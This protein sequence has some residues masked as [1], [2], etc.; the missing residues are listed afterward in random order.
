MQEQTP[1]EYLQDCVKIEPLC[2]EEEYIRLP[3]DMAYWNSRY[4]DVYRHWLEMKVAR[5]LAHN[6]LLME[7]REL[8][9][10]KSTSGRVTA[11]EV[12]SHV[13]QD[14]IYLDAK[15]KELVAES[16][17]IRLY[18]VMEALRAK[19]DMLISLGAHIRQERAN[20]P[21][22]RTQAHIDREVRR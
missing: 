6:R 15:A 20:D 21:M 3:G 10:A 17:K 16:E 14:P 8:L 4:S 1:E 7:H 13:V 19:R 11:A 9:L 22:I 2:I 12:E 5:D 18:G